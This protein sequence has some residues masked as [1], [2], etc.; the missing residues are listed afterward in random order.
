MRSIKLLIIV[1]MSSVLI[2][3]CSQ[4]NQSNVQNQADTFQWKTEQFADIKILRYQIPEFEKL[5]LNQKILLYYLSQ[6]ALS[7]RDILWDQNCKYNL[8]V[9]KNLENI[10]LTYQGD[11]NSVDFQK[12]VVYLKRVW[13]SNGIHH[14]YSTDKIKPEFTKEYFAELVK[15]S[16]Q[17]GFVKAS[18]K[19]FEETLK[20]LEKIMFDPQFLAKRV[21]LDPSQDLILSSANNYYDGV[22]QHEAEN[23]YNQMRDPKD[24]TPISYGLNSQLV[25]K[26]GKIYERVWKSGGMYGPAIDKIIFWLEKALP[27]AENEK[28]SEVIEKL[29][30]YYKSGSLK[31]W[32]EYNIA[33]VQDTESLVDFVNGFIEV[34][35]DPL[36]LKASWE[37]LVNFK[38]LEATHRAELLSKN[39]QWFEEHSPIDKRFKKEKVTGVTAKIINA[40]QLGGDLYPSTAIGINLPNADWIRKDY[41]SKSVTLENITYAYDQVSLGSG[42]YEEFIEN[43]DDLKL[44]KQ[45]K[46]LSDNIHTDLHECLGHGSGKLLPGVA[47]DAL[48]NYQST[49]EETRADLF[50]LYYIMDQK[51]VD[52][53]IIPNLEAAKAEYLYQMLNGLIIQLARIEPGKNLEEAHMRNR[54]LIAKW[55]YEKGKTD[56]VIEMYKKNEKTYVRIND[57]KKLRALIGQLLAEVQRIKSEGDFEAGKNLVETYGVIVD[58][59]L[60]DEV[61]KRYSKLNLAPYSG[62][63]NP[64]LIPITENGKIIDVKV[65]YP[66]D[67]AAQMIEYSQNYS[68]LPVEN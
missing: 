40:V 63:I 18:N 41:G 54:Q 13:F 49:L 5:S 56:N 55:C 25:K 57:Y 58:Q 43:S 24:N 23:Y 62:F 8:L 27:Y 11:R 14:H 53:G 33:W 4:P 64:K 42:L 1:I 16:D 15:N 35:G 50:A 68:F 12:F 37:A 7:G 9:R 19:T 3:S 6:A 52:L 36:G 32:D 48:K 46:A 30:R 59:N 29:I 20:L 67:F 39:A 61:H 26:N 2:L 60:R 65:E 44:V 51:L 28:Q 21:N 38:N 66:T 45:Y 22:T 10:Y 34:Y 47:S 31:D 17:S